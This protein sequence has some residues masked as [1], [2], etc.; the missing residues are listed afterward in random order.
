MASVRISGQN[1]IYIHKGGR[2]RDG[3]F[4]TSSDKFEITHYTPGGTA[5][6]AL[7]PWV[8]RVVVSG[9]DPTGCGRWT[10][11]TYSGEENKR[12]TVISA[13]RVGNQHQPGALTAPRQYRIQYQDESL[14]PYILD[15]QRQTMIDLEY[16]AK[17]LR[18][19]R[20]DIILF[21]TDAIM[22]E[23]NNG[24]N[25]KDTTWHSKRKTASM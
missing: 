25:H 4:G 3:E 7:G 22:K 10:F 9:S 19:K 23:L 6:I 8:Y 11:I 17:P 24:F 2:C 18:A 21:I 15:P 1:N 16:F 5:K 14:Q 13:Y 12:C 20:N